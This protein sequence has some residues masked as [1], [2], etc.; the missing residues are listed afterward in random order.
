MTTDYKP[1]KNGLAGK[2]LAFFAKNPSEEL[3]TWDICQKFG[4]SPAGI[5]GALVDAV[6]AGMLTLAKNADFDPCYG[7]GPNIARAFGDATPMPAPVSP[8]AETIETTMTKTAQ[9]AAKKA[10]LKTKPA[11]PSAATEKHFAP[12][13]MD[14]APIASPGENQTVLALP[15]LGEFVVRHDIA[16]LSFRAQAKDWAPALLGI[17]VGEYIAL[18]QKDKSAI[19]KSI[20]RAH[21]AKHG[22]WVRSET[23]QPGSIL[24]LRTA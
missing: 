22:K 24:V 15:G 10:T 18:P 11:K 8:A 3:T 19:Y 14:A 2:V 6:G 4:V 13:Q 12:V 17:K 16:A 1:H 23:R 7:P 20:A 9:P 5:K 21:H